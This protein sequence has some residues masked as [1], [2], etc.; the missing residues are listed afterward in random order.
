MQLNYRETP[1][2][3][4]F[5]KPKQVFK[6]IWSL[7]THPKWEKI[8]YFAIITTTNIYDKMH[9]NAKKTLT[10]GNSYRTTDWCW[11]KFFVSGGWALNQWGEDGNIG[12]STFSASKTM[13]ISQASA[14]NS[15]GLKGFI[16]LTMPL[17]D[18]LKNI[19]LL[20]CVQ[21]LT[22]FTKSRI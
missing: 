22:C 18:M 21:L 2:I 10:S 17:S 15:L 13:A 4:N 19:Q 6:K 1:Q 9:T 8:I 12:N 3:Q 16:V 14:P 7:K 20:L 5:G 11:K